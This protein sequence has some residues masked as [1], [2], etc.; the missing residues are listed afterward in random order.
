MPGSIGAIPDG[1]KL[2]PACGGRGI[3]PPQEIIMEEVRN[4][5]DIVIGWNGGSGRVYLEG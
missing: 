3:H 5:D 4:D 2:I 1:A